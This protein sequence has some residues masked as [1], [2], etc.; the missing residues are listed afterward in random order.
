MRRIDVLMKAGKRWTRWSELRCFQSLENII[1]Q[2]DGSIATLYVYI[3]G[4]EPP[5]ESR[6]Y[7]N[8]A[9]LP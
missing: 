6:R 5:N 7:F 9:I 8:A 2:E 1:V 4:N 3:R